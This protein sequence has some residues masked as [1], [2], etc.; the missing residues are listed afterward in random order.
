MENLLK[1]CSFLS[2]DRRRLPARMW[3]HGMS[4]GAMTLNR[5]GNL[6]PFF[7]FASLTLKGASS[8]AGEC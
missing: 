5:R 7:G 6:C 3:R 1:A 8:C 4:S 2:R